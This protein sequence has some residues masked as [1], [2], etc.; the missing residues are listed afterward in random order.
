MT[1][2]DTLRIQNRKMQT[3]LQADMADRRDRMMRGEL[4]W[5]DVTPQKKPEP[6]PEKPTLTP[7]ERATRDWDRRIAKKIRANDEVVLPMIAK[8]IREL[9][10][11]VE[12]LRSQVNALKAAEKRKWFA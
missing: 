1:D 3:E 2:N 11:E 8:V 5:P 12:A 7:Q 4:D 10:E 6:A 9:R